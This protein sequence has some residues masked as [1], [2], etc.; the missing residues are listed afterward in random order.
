[1]LL[2]PAGFE[3]E[4]QDPADP[5]AEAQPR[6][7]KVFAYPGTEATPSAKSPR[8]PGP[9]DDADRPPSSELVEFLELAERRMKAIERVADNAVDNVTLELERLLERLTAGGDADAARMRAA[10]EVVI[11]HARTV[12]EWSGGIRRWLESEGPPHGHQPSDGVVLLARRMALA[13]IS[14]S[15]IEAML[16]GLGVADPQAAVR[17]ALHGPID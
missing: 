11:N 12:S 17:H 14:N 5:P 3:S 2:T 16:A 1:M 15:K 4:H 7:A 13:G 10:G 6:L 9:V 8:S